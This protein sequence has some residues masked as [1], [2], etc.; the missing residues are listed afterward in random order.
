VAKSEVHVA[1]YSVLAQAPAQVVFDTYVRAERWPQ[2]FTNVVHTEY[3]SRADDQDAVE[4][5]ALQGENA[6]RHWV[7]R[8]TVD[9]SGL[10]VAF[11]NDPAPAP[12]A[13]AGGEW[14]FVPRPDGTTKVVIRHEFS[15]VEGADIP[16]ERIAKEFG[17]HS[18]RQLEELKAAA[19]R[20]QELVDLVVDFEDPLF[21]G[22][23]AQ[24]AWVMLYEADKWP[25]R[26][27]HVKAL[28]M[29]EDFDR[30]G[31]AASGATHDPDRSPSIQFFDMDTTTSD[32]RPHTTRSVRIC[33]PHRK[34]VYKQVQPP[35]LLEVHTGHWSFT[36]TREG[37][38]VGARHTVTIR[39]RMLHLLGDGTTIDD[40][41]RYLRRVLSTN[42][43][44]NL[45]LA[46]SYAEERADG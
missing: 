21:V 9:A 11:T 28:T 42:S 34:I 33:L 44:T 23:S 1:E 29:T 32:G 39:P 27:S 20:A 16:P 15:L 5:W 6:V 31:S 37:V 45:R 12:L 25:E 26:L 36:P 38:I 19:E 3:V 10:R 35:P 43:M 2:L 46:K 4:I 8:R 30:S 14:A 18:V 7:S 40:A 41:R 22:G 13:E 24:D 17:K